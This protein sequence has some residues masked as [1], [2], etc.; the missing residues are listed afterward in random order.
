MKYFLY[1]LSI[2]Y[3]ILLGY[4]L[5]I[6]FTNPGEIPSGD[7]AASMFELALILIPSFILIQVISKNL[8]QFIPVTIIVLLTWLPIKN[9]M[10]RVNLFDLPG[11]LI[12]LAILFAILIGAYLF[13]SNLKKE[14]IIKVNFFIALITFVSSGIE[15]TIFQVNNQNK[16][17]NE[18]V[19]GI[20]AFSVENRLISSVDKSNFPNIIY[21]VPDRYGSLASLKQNFNFDNSGFYKS[22][23]DRSFI[24]NSGSRSNYPFTELSL[25]STLNNSYLTSSDENINESS[26]YPLIKD[27]SAFRKIKDSGYKF[28][29]FDNWW[30]GSSDVAYADYNFMNLND[31][32]LSKPLSQLYKIQTPIYSILRTI[33]G[34]N[35]SF[36]QCS[37]LDTYFEEIERI[38]TTES[39]Q[40]KF[41]FAHLL[42]PHDPYLLDDKGE[43][44]SN[45]IQFSNIDPASYS[46]D[47][48]WRSRVNLYT[49][50][51]I[52]TNKKILELFDKAKSRSSR[53]FIFVIQS[54]EGPYPRCFLENTSGDYSNCSKRDWDIKTG[55]INAMYFSNVGKFDESDLVSPINN[56]NIIF[57]QLDEHDYANKEHLFF[58]LNEKDKRMAFSPN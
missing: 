52:Y 11:S 6:F 26:L 29:N 23:R 57:T 5:I 4:I 19:N 44:N 1:N 21:I 8:S 38:I 10:S 27:S 28:Y 43:C 50:Y 53:D 48:I 42:A 2:S 51:L 56:F 54:D 46:E 41:I 20:N 47:I 31:D 22:L 30:F 13:L 17:S 39:D 25:S 12:S 16:D 9:F 45:A 33:L 55:I 58:I 7:L 18:L 15:I 24:V 34:D 14:N 35:E 40:P 32:S 37:L 3:I 36:R 49:K